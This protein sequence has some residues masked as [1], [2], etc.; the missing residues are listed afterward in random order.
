MSGFVNFGPWPD[1]DTGVDGAG[2]AAGRA[3][4]D[5][6]RRLLVWGDSV[7]NRDAQ[8]SGAAAAAAAAAAGFVVV[9][10]GFVGGGVV[11]C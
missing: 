8:V 4:L 10:G 9:G 2:G 3:V 7:G 5:E 6:G 1:R 11:L